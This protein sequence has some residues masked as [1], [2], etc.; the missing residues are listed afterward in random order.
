MK[1]RM[2]SYASSLPARRR[3]TR[4]TASSRSFS[5]P[6]LSILV[7]FCCLCSFLATRVEGKRD[8]GDLKLSSIVTEQYLTK[9]AA[10]EGYDLT[11]KLD[12][13]VPHGFWNGRHALE[14]D[15]FSESGFRTFKTK[16]DKGSLCDDRVGHAHRRV[17]IARRQPDGG[18]GR[19]AWNGDDIKVEAK[20]KNEDKSQVY[21]FYV[22]DCA[23]EWYNAKVRF[24]LLIFYLFFLSLPMLRLTIAFSF[25][26]LSTR[27]CRA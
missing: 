18:A 10:N 1:K 8:H 14:L 16:L 13:S 5:P 15:I 24:L 7:A 2:M 11:L 27:T 9:F 22:T 23:L 20:W 12:V 25:T 17:R 26:F 6:L 3:T 4:G 21:Y 19:R